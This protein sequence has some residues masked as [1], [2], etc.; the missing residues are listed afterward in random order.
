MKN[1]LIYVN[2][3]G[4]DLESE[5]LAKIQIENSLEIGWKPNDIINPY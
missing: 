3:Q 5:K 4:F 2:P 1:L